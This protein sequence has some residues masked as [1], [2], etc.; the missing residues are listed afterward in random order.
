MANE[1]E[2]VRLFLQPVK[3]VLQGDVPTEYLAK[4]FRWELENA[5][6]RVPSAFELD[7]DL[8]VLSD[9]LV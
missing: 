2:V 8:L 6:Q 9:L 4:D 1:Q 5:Q 7:K 3:V